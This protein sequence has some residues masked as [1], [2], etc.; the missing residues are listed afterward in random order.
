M[1][2]AIRMV[3]EWSKQRV[4]WGAPVG[5]HEAVAARIARMA[6][7]TLAVESLTW[8]TSALAD[9][10]DTDIRLEAALAKLYCTETM[11]KT[12]DSALQV[13]GGRGYETADSLAGR[14]EAPM[15]MERMLRDARI[16]LIIEG[17]SEIM[18]LF[19]AREALDPHLKIA[20]ASATSARIK[21][22][23]AARYYA[24]WYPK[25]WLPR[26]AIPQAK[27]LPRSLKRHLR[28]VERASRMLA[29]DLF[30]ML[31]RHRQ[32]LQ[33]KQQ[34]LGRLV[35]SG[36][37]LFAMT[38]VLSRA[39]APDRPVGCEELADLFCRQA[40]RRIKG[41]H[42][43]IYC[44][45]DRFAYRRARDLLDGGYPWLEENIYSSWHGKHDD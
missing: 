32:G 17:T 26:R 3:R 7:D 44:N 25:L 8:L 23:Q 6:A 43:E 24:R 16:N 34:V 5:H 42:K 40:R 27:T 45:D 18:K 37:E 28:F 12:V 33:R 15:P 14:G 22:V 10:G 36:A 19:I 35:D 30:H 13:R 20:G 21:V 11:W 9:R 1:K 39:A 31:L 4:Q 41:W 38:A 29:R 2:Q